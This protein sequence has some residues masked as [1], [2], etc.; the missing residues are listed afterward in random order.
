MSTQS[1]MSI[2]SNLTT[3]EDIIL[4]DIIQTYRPTSILSNQEDM[5]W[6]DVV[7]TYQP[8]VSTQD[9][10][11]SNMLTE[12]TT[13]SW[14]SLNLDTLNNT[15]YPDIVQTYQVTFDDSD[16]FL[17]DTVWSGIVQTYSQESTPISWNTFR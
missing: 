4:S 8:P 11:W 14:D 2:T 17:S 6:S 9:T 12:N 7:Q 15:I 3:Q 5:C 13:I 1:T 10:V 16:L